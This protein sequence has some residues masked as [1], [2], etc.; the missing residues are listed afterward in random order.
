MLVTYQQ[1]YTSPQLYI[2]PLSVFAS[3]TLRSHVNAFPAIVGT[4][5][6]FGATAILLLVFVP[7]VRLQT[8]VMFRLTAIIII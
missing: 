8:A 4:A 5:H 6:Y 3:F 7:R 2:L 1:P